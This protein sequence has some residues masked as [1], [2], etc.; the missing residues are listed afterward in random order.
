MCDTDVF[1]IERH[2]RVLDKSV[3]V[4]EFLPEEKLE[5]IEY[6]ENR[7]KELYLSLLGGDFDFFMSDINNLLS[8]RSQ[9]TRK[10]ISIYLKREND[11]E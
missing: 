10:F 2:L 6:A 3:S 4:D 7:L 11:D 1:T 9:D 5:A 8:K